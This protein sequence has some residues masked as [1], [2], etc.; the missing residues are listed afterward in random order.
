MAK[1]AVVYLG[2]T[3]PHGIIRHFV[4]LAFEIKQCIDADPYADFYF[5]STDGE[6]GQNCW[7]DVRAAFPE[8]RILCTYTFAELVQ[9]IE[10]LFSRYE[11]VVVHSGG[12]WGQTKFF[13]P[14]KR[15]YG[16]RLQHVVTTHSYRLGDP[17]LRVPMSALQYWLYSRYADMV[18]FQCSFA[19]RMFVGGERLLARGRGCIIPLGCEPNISACGEV[20]QAICE[21]G[22]QA[23]FL[24]E[25]LRR[26][27]YLAGFR[28]G[29]KHAW[30]VCALAEFVK[31]HPEVRLYFCGWLTGKTAK[32]VQRLI[33][34]LG[35]ERQ[36]VCT[37]QIS[38][39]AVPWVLRHV[40]AAVVPSAAETFGHN[41][42]EPMMA[43]LPVI[44]TRVGAGEYAIQDYRTGL[45]FSL[46]DPVSVVRAFAY[47]VNHPDEA[48]Q[49]GAYAAKL[50]HEEF[51]HASVGIA[52]ARLYKRMIGEAR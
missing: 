22:L 32:D 35:L 11:V 23:E 36:I 31:R 33:A 4:L 41:Y 49:M 38:R 29:K 40:D 42:I 51:T 24:D 19:V 39:D 21:K 44:G 27:V 30:L 13:V 50:A 18:V 46:S 34:R 7:G 20:P 9:Q 2:M 1:H 17:L 25:K 47:F 52:L 28:P 16:P 37:G 8:N 5:A 12:G 10:R 3:Y 45:G 14:L 48:R 6:T 43:G 26:F 15:K